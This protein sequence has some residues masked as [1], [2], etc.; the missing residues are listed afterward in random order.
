MKEL[1]ELAKKQGY[2]FRDSYSEQKQIVEIWAF[3][4]SPFNAEK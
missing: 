2:L 4:G 1:N 3:L